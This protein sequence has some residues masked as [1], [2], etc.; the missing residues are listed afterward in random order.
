MTDS[1]LESTKKVLGLATEYTAF[2]VDVLMHINTAFAD[3]N[4]VGIGPVE[5]FEVTDATT[6]WEDFLGTNNFPLNSVKSFVVLSVRLRFDPPPT[7]FGINAMKDQLEEL[8]W[9]INVRREEET[10]PWTPPPTVTTPD[11]FE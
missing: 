1:I 5:G 8:I 7:S 4:Q 9:R 11:P 2:D 6:K 3:L 10:Y